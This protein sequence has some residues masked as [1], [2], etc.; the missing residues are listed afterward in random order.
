MDFWQFGIYIVILSG[1]SSLV[2]M[3]I[4]L[5]VRKM[6]Q[7]KSPQARFK[8]KTATAEWA[9]IPSAKNVVT[10]PTPPAPSPADK[11]EV[12]HEEA[13]QP[14]P[15]PQDAGLDITEETSLTSPLNVPGTVEPASLAGAS[16][17]E[18]PETTDTLLTGM[19]GTTSEEG[20]NQTNEEY[21]IVEN[22]NSDP[23]SIFQIED[24]QENP[25]SELSASLPDIDTS[26]LLREGKEVL[27]IL[28]I[29]AEDQ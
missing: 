25:A 7:D 28:G 12:A 26:S 27:R 16:V 8:S 29:E 17:L 18:S 6:N 23:L 19:T 5:I 9:R 10:S 21:D 20:D 1:A 4:V 11:S 14:E 13:I 2:I 24:A 3:T 15:A 22:D